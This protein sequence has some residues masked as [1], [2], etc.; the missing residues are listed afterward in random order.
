M[1]ETS[2]AGASNDIPVDEEHTIAVTWTRRADDDVDYE[3]FLDGVSKESDTDTTAAN[4]SDF[5][6][7]AAGRGYRYSVTADHI[8]YL[9]YVY[10]AVLDADTLL[11]IHNDPYGMWNTA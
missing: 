10:N 2:A 11:A 6:S 3:I 4:W 7:L 8:A 1:V 5:E 9:D